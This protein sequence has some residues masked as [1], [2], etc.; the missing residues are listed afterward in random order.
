MANSTGTAPAPDRPS[1]GE[2]HVA[3]ASLLSALQHSSANPATSPAGQS[4]VGP[5]AVHSSPAYHNPAPP[6]PPPL[7]SSNAPTP[8]SPGESTRAARPAA[9]TAKSGQTAAELSELGTYELLLQLGAHLGVMDPTHNNNNNRGEPPQQPQAQPAARTRRIS[10]TTRES[11]TTGP[12]NAASH[13]PATS[14]HG[15]TVYKPQPTRSGRVPQLPRPASA[16]EAASSTDPTM[17][18]LLFNDFFDFPSSE[19]E[20]DDP[21]FDPNAPSSDFWGDLL[22]RERAADGDLTENEDGWTTATT[23]TGGRGGMSTRASGESGITSDEFAREI[24]LLTSALNDPLPDLSQPFPPSAAVRISPRRSRPTTTTAAFEDDSSPAGVES[25][26]AAVPTPPPRKKRKTTTTTTRRRALSP[27]LEDDVTERS[28]GVS[29][30]RSGA[31]E[32]PP[33]VART[34][35]ASAPSQPQPQPAA[36]PPPPQ[37]SLPIPPALHT[38][39]TPVSTTTASP[40]APTAAPAPVP[41]PAPAP[42]KPARKP[43]RRMF[44]PEEAAQRRREQA[45]ERMALKRKEDKEKQAAE[46]VRVQA[47]EAENAMLREKCRWLEERC[48]DLKR[49]LVA[50]TADSRGHGEDFAYVSAATSNGPSGT[51]EPT[52]LAGESESDGGEYQVESSEESSSSDDDDGDDGGVDGDEDPQDDYELTP[53]AMPLL[54]PPPLGPAAPPPPPLSSSSTTTRAERVTSTNAATQ[55]PASVNLDLASMGGPALSQLLTLVHAAAH[56][57]GIPLPDSASAP[58]TSTSAGGS[59]T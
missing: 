23:P 6:A 40:A 35:R 31:P 3:L 46:A 8:V 51:A 29:L 26:P 59:S 33:S 54:P 12:P 4:P 1:L 57:Q 11:T 43:R 52:P 15:N 2:A 7:S 39:P 44:T 55:D 10:S 20:D 48:D 42:E 16:G 32:L 24:A 47:I 25:S 56:A 18:T 36:L 53:L 13:G 45:A 58:P 21:D 38:R 22:A 14:Q 17:S 28:D 41:V 30:H 37:Y 27:V 9:A 49:R 50:A 5:A 19:D 34:S